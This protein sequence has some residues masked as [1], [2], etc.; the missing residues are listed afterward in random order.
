MD[1]I[2]WQRTEGWQQGRLAACLLVP[3]SWER[4]PASSEPSSAT[5]SA[6]SGTLPSTCLDV[7]RGGCELIRPCKETHTSPVLH[8]DVHDASKRQCAGSPCASLLP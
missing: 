5:D 7:T 3:V 6:M 8:A 4:R 1:T 2:A